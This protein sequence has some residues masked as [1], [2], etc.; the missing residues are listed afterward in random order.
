MRLFV[1]RFIGSAARKAR[2]RTFKNPYLFF[3]LKKII[4]NET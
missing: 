2:R 3:V 4:K 1:I